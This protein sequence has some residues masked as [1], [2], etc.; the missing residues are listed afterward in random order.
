MGHI[1]YH[2]HTKGGK[3]TYTKASSYRPLSMASYIGKLLERI[4]D[5]RL[6]MFIQV[7]DELDEEQEGFIAGR[8]TTRYLFKLMANLT[9]IKRQRLACIILFVDFEKAYDSVHLP[10]LIVKLKRFGICGKFLK[11]LHSF[12]FK[13]K[14]CLKVN[15]ITGTSRYCSLYG[16]PQGSVIAP[17]LFILY[18]SDMTDHIP[19]WLKKWLSCYK[20]ADDGTLL[21][22]HHNMFK[23]YRL[24][25]RLCN[26]LSKWCAKNKMVINCD[27]NKT[28]A[29]ILHTGNKT[30]NNLPPELYIGEKTIKYVKSTKVLGL[31]ID[32]DLSFFY[33]AEQKLKDCTKKWGMLTKATNRNHG[34]NV[35]SLLLLLKTTVLTK[36]FYAGPI[37][38]YKNQALFKDFWNGVI[39][40]LTGA[41]LNPPRQVCELALHLPPLNVQLDV[42]T[43]KFFCKLLSV[44]DGMAA[45]LIQTDGS[46]RKEL[47]SQLIALSFGRIMESSLG[48]FVTSN[49][50]T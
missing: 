12:L 10:T 8:S 39:M 26:E 11:L 47:H 23:C 25:Q 1:I 21:I 44:K 36:L 19:K 41:T 50:L 29:I 14:V 17:F 5:Q 6:R 30:S 9:E 2:I 32:E 34:L 24:M 7:E 45:A 35:H 22:T 48:G 20:F 15:K 43:V 40:K 28:E 18:I 38:L 4:L 27:I 3:K 16:L 49:L 46:L 42:L 13:R 33:H 31:I 37:W